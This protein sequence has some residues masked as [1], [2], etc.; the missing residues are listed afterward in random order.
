MNEWFLLW[1]TKQ[2]VYTKLLD[3]LKL[4]DF[5]N[6]FEHPLKSL[7][8]FLIYGM[9]RNWSGRRWEEKPQNWKSTELAYL[10]LP[11]HQLPKRQ[12]A[13]HFIPSCHFSMLSINRDT[14]TLTFPFS[15][16]LACSD[17]TLVRT[18]W[19]TS[20]QENKV[21]RR[22]IRRKLFKLERLDF[23]TLNSC[24]TYLRTTIPV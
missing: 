24:F 19:L 17:W 12:Q 11:F 1:S 13:I 7:T 20:A 22:S 9:F 2:Q 14:T 21:N 10:S 15:A 16:W 4:R 5:Q 3:C 23:S 8:P 18:L 6:L